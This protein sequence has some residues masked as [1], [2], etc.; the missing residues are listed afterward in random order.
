[1][2][3]PDRDR[4]RIDAGFIDEFL[5]GIGVGELGVG[6]VNGDML[7]DAAELPEFGFDDETFRVR[8]VGDALRN[9]D[10]LVERFGGRVD[11]RPRALRLP[12]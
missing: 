9:R 11:Q 5:D 8:R 4:E 12:R 2:A 7:L 3:G 1:M 10:V 6:F